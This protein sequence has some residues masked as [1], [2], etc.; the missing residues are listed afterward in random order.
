MGNM[1]RESNEFFGVLCNLYVIALLAALPLYT[2]EGYWMLGDTKYLLFRNVSFLCLGCWLVIGL[3]GRIRAAAGGVRMSGEERRRAL[4]QA[5]SP[6]DFAVASYGVCV[7]ISALCTAY[8]RLAWDGYEGWFMGAVSQLLFVGIYF[9]VSMQYDGAAWP[10]YL[11]EL[12]LMGVTAF[13]LLHRLGIDPLGLHRW[14]NPN[15]WEYSHMLST[16]G[17]INWLCGF[18]SVVLALPVIHFLR[19]ERRWMQIFAYVVTVSALVL[20]GIQGSQGGLLILGVCA[21]VCVFLGR[22]RPAVLRKV[23]LLW[24]GFFLCMALI[25]QCI[26][27]RGE[28]AAMAADGNIFAVTKWYF[29][30]GGAIL[31]WAL[32]L[33]TGGNRRKARRKKSENFGTGE[34]DKNRE[35]KEG[36]R[37]LRD[38]RE[39]QNKSRNLGNRRRRALVMVLI[40]CILVPVTVWGFLRFL[41]GVDDSFGSGRGLLW[42]IALESFEQADWKGKLIG[43]GPDCYAEAVFNRLGW[44]SDV[45]AGEHWEFA[46][47]TNAHNEILNQLCN[48]GILGAVSYLGIFAA[49]LWRYHSWRGRD[50]IPFTW[51]GVLALAMYGAH[52]LVSFQQ[53]LNTPLLFLVLGL[54][55]REMRGHKLYF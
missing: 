15:D 32:A 52:S 46:V 31:C 35:F 54:C 3:P 47:F 8:G 5:F 6:V 22:K 20:L 30:V 2:G 43:A 38:K 41:E 23:S 28:K 17:N 34:K 9:F 21:A 36:I 7:T 1:R 4:A 42:R 37:E 26:K 45:W 44:A 53:V 33:L 50:C 11:G 14:W 24:A 51:V 39:A 49:G 10:L 40:L 13:G 48:T 29:W 19:E 16:L 55:E 18:Y 25:G 27:M 12:A